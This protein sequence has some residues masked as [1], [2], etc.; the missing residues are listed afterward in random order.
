[1]KTQL[2]EC[3]DCGHQMRLTARSKHDDHTI[4]CKRCW[5]NDWMVLTDW[6]AHGEGYAAKLGVGLTDLI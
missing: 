1:M 4:L 6:V 5:C 2:L 3:V